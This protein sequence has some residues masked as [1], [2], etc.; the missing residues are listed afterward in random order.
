M[1]DYEEYGGRIEKG[2]VQFPISDGFLPMSVEAS[3]TVKEGDLLAEKDDQE[4]YAAWQS[5]NDAESERKAASKT[6]DAKRLAAAETKV[7]SARESR[8]RALRE[9]P[10]E[11][12]VAP[13][14]GK[15]EQRW[16]SVAGESQ[17]SSL[18]IASP[19]SLIVSF[20]VPESV[21]LAH[22]RAPDRK[23]ELG[24]FTAGRV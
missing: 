8:D 16:T 23:P 14:S 15:I 21:V 11:K 24:A 1:C 4:V 6:N 19:D 13:F 9:H 12:I 5:L 18:S 22:R 17:Y 20:D 7:K 2:I 10:P 3:A